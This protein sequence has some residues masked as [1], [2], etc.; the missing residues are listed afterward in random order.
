M[1]IMESAENNKIRKIIRENDEK[2]NKQDEERKSKNVVTKTKASTTKKSG[3]QFEGGVDVSQTT[4]NAQAIQAVSY[5]ERL[6]QI[7]VKQEITPTIFF[8]PDLFTS[9]P[10]RS[11]IGTVV[12][13]QAD[14]NHNFGLGS[15]DQIQVGTDDS[16]FAEHRP[17]QFQTLQQKR[18]SKQ[19]GMKLSKQDSETRRTLDMLQ[20]INRDASNERLVRGANIKE[21]EEPARSYIKNLVE[22]RETKNGNGYKSAKQSAQIKVEDE[23]YNDDEYL[24]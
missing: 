15:Q 24:S 5:L 14:V 21:E 7:K 1:P 16:Y 17:S 6:S 12:T 4:T 3:Q 19:M 8:V 9:E 2:L 20:Q 23:D 13:K 11:Q 18:S 22:S 10:H